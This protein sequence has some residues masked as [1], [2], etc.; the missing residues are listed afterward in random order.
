VKKKKN[1]LHLTKRE[2]TNIEEMK[3]RG[4]TTHVKK[5]ITEEITTEGMKKGT[6]KKEEDHK[7]EGTT[8]KK[9]D[10]KIEDTKK[11]GMTIT[12]V[13]VT[14]MKNIQEKEKD[15][16]MREEITDFKIKTSPF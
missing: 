4:I 5:E 12:V 10:M 1:H 15:T 14:V 9:E 8:K 6:T 13:V 16:T 7:K 3:T 2:T 11:E